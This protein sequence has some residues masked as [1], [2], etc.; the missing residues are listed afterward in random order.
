MGTDEKRQ[1]M[2]L[3]HLLSR[4]RVVMSEIVSSFLR[5]G[6]ILNKICREESLGRGA[7]GVVEAEKGRQREKVEK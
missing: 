7:K 2:A 1:F 3:K 6:L 4:W 5:A